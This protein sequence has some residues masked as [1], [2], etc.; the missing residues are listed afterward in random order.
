MVVQ[1][2]SAYQK[3]VEAAERAERAETLAAVREGLADLKAGRTKPA[4]SAWKHLAK[5]HGIHVDE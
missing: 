2:A 4:R 5:K 3:L 1:E